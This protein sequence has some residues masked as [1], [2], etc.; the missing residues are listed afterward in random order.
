MPTPTVQVNLRLRPELHERVAK[1]ASARQ[2]SATRWMIEAI[3]A[4]AVAEEGSER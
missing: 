2:I 4:A 1:L 3:E